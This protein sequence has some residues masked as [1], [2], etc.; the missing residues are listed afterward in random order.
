MEGRALIGPVSRMALLGASLIWLCSV[1]VS[2]AWLSGLVSTRETFNDPD[3]MWHP[4]S[5][6]D[7]SRLVLGLIVTVVTVVYGYLLLRWI[8]HGTLSR[9]WSAVL[10]PAAAVAA[11]GGLMYE[12]T[13]APVIGANIGGGL[14]VLGAGPFV[15]IM[16]IVSIVGVR[17]SS[18]PA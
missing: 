2:V 10:I 3:Y 6:S 17:R 4:L 7:S 1:V 15:V 13:T 11:Y 8:Q 14:M 5:L 16:A 18:P 12:V 9:R